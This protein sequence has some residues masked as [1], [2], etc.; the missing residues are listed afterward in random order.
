MNVFRLE[1]KNTWKSTLR[2]AIALGGITY[3]LLAFFPSMQSESMKELAGAKM[4]GIDPALLE[5]LGLAELT[6]FT[7]ITN[8]FGY[9]LQYMT[10]A[11]MVLVTQLAVNSLVKEETDGTI[12]F[13]YSK[14]VSR[15]SILLQKTLANIFSFICILIFLYIVAVIGYLSYSDYNFAE[16]MKEAAVF[17]SAILYVGFVFMALGV[18]LSTLIKSSKG[19]SGIVIAIVFG[20]FILGIMGVIVDDLSFLFYL[21]P[22]DWINRQKLMTEGIRMEEWIVGIL[23]ILICYIAAHEIYKKKDLRS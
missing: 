8:F 17:Y 16:S 11:I 1:L 10:L 7:V 5:A 3:M 9:V 4:E 13:L 2:W 18:F 20:T 19:S 15:S 23:T 12:E 14:P 21:S 22:M 6:D